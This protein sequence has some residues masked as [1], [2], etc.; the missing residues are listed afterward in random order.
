MGTPRLVIA[1]VVAWAG[2]GG[3]GGVRLSAQEA[4]AELTGCYDATVGQWV[5]ETYAGELE[6]RPGDSGD[7]RWERLPRRLRLLAPED[8]GPIDISIVAPEGS[9]LRVA[10][11]IMWAKVDGASLR[12]AF[13][14]GFSG[15]TATLR[16]S[17]DGWSGIAQTFTDVLP[18][19]VNARTVLLSRADC[20]APLRP[21]SNIR[22]RCRGSC[23]WRTD[24]SS[25]WA[26]RF[27]SN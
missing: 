21:R 20:D 5:V 7:Y 12:L 8:G 1:G 2:A 3:M 26:L 10:R 11:R 4:P 24:R 17:G 22:V 25:P 23:N 9:G 18:H 16:R 19:Q 27:P 14:N 13:S 15:M 6:P